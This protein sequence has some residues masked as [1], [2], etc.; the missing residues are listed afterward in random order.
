MLTSPLTRLSSLLLPW[1]DA[2]D[3]LCPN[4][5]TSQPARSSLSGSL[6][7]GN[8]K[9]SWPPCPK[10][11]ANRRPLLLIH[12]NP[13]KPNSSHQPS[14]PKFPHKNPPPKMLPPPQKNAFHHKALPVIFPLHRLFLSLISLSI[15]LLSYPLLFIILSYLILTFNVLSPPVYVSLNKLN[16]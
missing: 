15:Y 4:R 14:P 8:R 10:P 12:R 2:T 1:S 3:Q 7:P 5:L 11:P 9:E 16:Y 6:A 13:P